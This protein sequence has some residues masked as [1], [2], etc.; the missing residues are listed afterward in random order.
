L[1]LLIQN[2]H[3][4]NYNQQ[5]VQ[6]GRKNSNQQH[7]K[8]EEVVQ[9]CN[10][11]DIKFANL[12]KKMPHTPHEGESKLKIKEQQYII[13]S[14]GP[15]RERPQTADKSEKKIESDLYNQYNMNKKL[16]DEKLLEKPNIR[17][18]ENKP[19]V[20]PARINSAKKLSQQDKEG[21]KNSFMNDNKDATQ[22]INDVLYL[23]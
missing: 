5:I 12:E 3:A 10:D 7:P 18:I 13:P 9:K 22:F 21:H 11:F 1:K 19:M 20:L 17:M 16:L 6:S 4:S 15:T 14:S 23:T 2:Q 8:M